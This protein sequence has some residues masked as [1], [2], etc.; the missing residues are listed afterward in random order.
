MRTVLLFIALIFL[1]SC[2]KQEP[3]PPAAADLPHATVV[4]RDGSRATGTVAASTPSEITLNQD[5][6]GTRTIS[7]KDVRRVDYGD[8]PP[9][10]AAKT[11]S[12]APEPTHEDHYHPPAAAITSKT[13]VLP[14]GTELPVRVEETIDSAHAVEGQVYAA[15]ISADVRDDAGAVVI[16]RGSNAQVVIKSASKGG[17]IRGASDLVL[18]LK[19][20]SIEGQQYVLNTTDVEEKGHAGVGKNKRTAEFA[21]GGAAIGAIIGAIAG[22]G[23]GAAIGAGAGAGAGAIT[24]VATKGKI[25]VPAETVLTFK[26]DAPLRVVEAM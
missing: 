20:V 24:Q 15:E 21:G 12:P 8:A 23:K 22:G 14:A 11:S 13:R 16:P 25:K 1:A 26:L 4:L 3:A 10:A 9:A 6:G 18:D 7:M 17:K 5:G 19:T 2:S